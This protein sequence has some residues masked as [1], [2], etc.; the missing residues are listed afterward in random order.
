MLRKVAALAVLL[1]V[2]TVFP[3]WGQQVPEGKKPFVPREGD[4]ESLN[5]EMTP[6]EM[7]HLLA[8]LEGEW[9]FESKRWILADSPPT[10]VQGES[11][12]TMILGGRFL[13]E[14]QKGELMGAAFEGHL[15]TG[16]DNR[17]KEFQAAW[18]DNFGTGILLA[19]G[20]LGAD[21]KSIELEAEALNPLTSRREKLRLITRIVDKDHHV[22]E[23]WAKPAGLP[24]YK[25]VETR[26]Q[27]R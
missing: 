9:S 18:I 10:V 22:F 13:E 1:L 14:V 16:W 27:R 11:S 5:Q 17:A 19:H 24:E 20:R 8:S 4:L 25:K 23:S 15:V 3:F 12:K 21:G 6:G 26:Y 7:H 2:A